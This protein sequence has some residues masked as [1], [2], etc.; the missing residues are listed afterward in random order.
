MA[1]LRAAT[2]SLLER[3][4]PFL[5]VC[6]GHQVLAGL[7]G[8]D[9]T[10]KDIVFQGTQTRLRVLGHEQVV[11]FYNT[12]VA[13]VP[14]GGLPPGVRVE[15]DPATGDIHLLAGPHYRSVQFHAESILSQ[16][17]AG[18]LRELVSDLLG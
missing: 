1:T 12:F 10:Y 8:L 9:L 11:G 5:A 4:R 17:G 2:A 18:V 3:G 15:T 6:L 16:H 7:L 14:A 13:R